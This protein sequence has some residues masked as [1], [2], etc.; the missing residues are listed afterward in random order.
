MCF[1]IK[2]PIDDLENKNFPDLDKLS[3]EVFAASDAKNEPVKSSITEKDIEGA[4]YYTFVKINGDDHE[5]HL[6]EADL[7]SV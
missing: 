1:A 3:K 5:L 7:S 2:C 6:S 4:R